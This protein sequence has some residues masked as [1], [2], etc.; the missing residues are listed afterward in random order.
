MKR[1]PHVTNGAWPCRCLSCARA[2]I[3]VRLWERF[4]RW[5]TS[6]CAPAI[7]EKNHVLRYA[8]GRPTGRNGGTAMQGTEERGWRD[9]GYQQMKPIGPWPYEATAK[10]QPFGY[11][12]KGWPGGSNPPS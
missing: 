9:R 7:S 12:T 11:E 1:H 2:D 4:S 8:S 10:V 6:Y 5:H 3:T